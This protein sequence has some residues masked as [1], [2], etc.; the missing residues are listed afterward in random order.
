MLEMAFVIDI[1][2]S[3]EKNLPAIYYCLKQFDK[4]DVIKKFRDLDAQN[5]VLY[6]LCYVDG[7]RKTEEDITSFTSMD[8]LLSDLKKQKVV[9]GNSN[10]VDDPT[11]AIQALCSHFENTDNQKALVVF[12]DYLPEESVR[13]Q[14]AIDYVLFYTDDMDKVNYRFDG[15]TES[16]Q[17]FSQ[18]INSF[19]PSNLR[20]VETQENQNG[21]MILSAA[22][23]M[24]NSMTNIFNFSSILM[25]VSS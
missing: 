23:F 7:N 24:N 21:D 1:T 13:I 15:L 19:S 6:Y 3:N 25:K 4:S 11:S 17:T 20:M 2:A 16:K 22:D 12:A 5:R 9:N 14:G 10:G 8:E 18:A